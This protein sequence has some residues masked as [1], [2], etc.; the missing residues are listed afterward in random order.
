MSRQPNSR[1]VPWISVEGVDGAG[2]S[3][4]IHTIVSCLEE[5]GFR[6][7]STREPGGTDLGERLRE[8]ILNTKMDLSTEVLLAFASRAEHLAKVINPALE[9][10]FAVVCDRFTD[11]TYA[12]QG[13]GQGFPIQDIDTLAAIVQKGAKPNLTLIFD[14]PPEVSAQRLAG[15]GKDPDKFES[16][17]RDYFAAVRQKYLDIAAAEPDRVKIIDSTKPLAEVSAQVKE[18]V[19][20]FLQSWGPAPA[21]PSRRPHP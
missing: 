6:V 19:N 7:V 11:S 17:S 18:V 2:K 4:H 1:S 10:N 8:E 15:T 14:V 5:A 12:Y 20:D 16:Q 3:S 21:R 9:N 13:A